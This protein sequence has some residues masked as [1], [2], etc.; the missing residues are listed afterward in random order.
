M[1]LEQE[2]TV[3]VTSTYQE[4][5]EQLK[6]KNFIQEEYDVNDIYMI[7]TSIEVNSISRLEYYKI[8]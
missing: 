4:L 3:L 1:K 8:V 5:H 2:I 7:P 6:K